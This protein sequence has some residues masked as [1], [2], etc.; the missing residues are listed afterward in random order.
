LK[1]PI[2][3]VEKAFNLNDW[4][5][6]GS[7]AIAYLIITLLP[8]RFTK[9][10]TVLIYIFCPTTAAMLDNSIGGHIFDFYDIMDGPAYTVM[11]F[12][13][14]FLYAPFGYFFLYFYERLHIHGLKTVVYIL[15]WTFVAVGFESLCWICGV[16]HYKHGYGIEYSFC[17]YLGSQT[18]TVLFYHFIADRPGES[19][20]LH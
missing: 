9:A 10:Q 18:A 19:S 14:Y 7:I 6:L 11:D 5:V 3:F 8:K 12:V 2:P 20:S 1:S 16:F 4:F 15:I 17:V 13:V